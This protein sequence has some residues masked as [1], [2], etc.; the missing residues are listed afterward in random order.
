MEKKI[1]SENP[2]YLRRLNLTLQMD[3]AKNCSKLCFHENAIA[4]LHFGCS[5]LER[6]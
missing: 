4:L 1:K 5:N 6:K 3:P 2:V